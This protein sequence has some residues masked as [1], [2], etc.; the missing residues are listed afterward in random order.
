MDRST[1]V[2]LSEID[3][4]ESNENL[5][6]RTQ[7]YYPFIESL[8]TYSSFNWII[9]LYIFKIFFSFLRKVYRNAT[10]MRVTLELSLGNK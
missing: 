5:E 1:S 6:R 7:N 3:V 4:T 9:V 2:S 8:I 10:I